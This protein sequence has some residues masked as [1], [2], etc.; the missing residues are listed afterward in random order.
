MS[1]KNLGEVVE[2]L[3]SLEDGLKLD[4]NGLSK[5]QKDKTGDFI[6]ISAVGGKKY[7]TYSKIV[8]ET[9]EK[10]Q[11]AKFDFTRDV[12]KAQ[13][14]MATSAEGNEYITLVGQK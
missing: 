1:N 5:V 8:I 7:R 12:L 14:K 4:I 11:A 10:V 2:I 13:V 6:V 3:E 9:L